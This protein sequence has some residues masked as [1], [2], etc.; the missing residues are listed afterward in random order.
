MFNF[1][2]D[3]GATLAVS[4]G[5]ITLGAIAIVTQA[6]IFLL[7]PIGIYYAIKFLREVTS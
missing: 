2:K 3:I 7:V 5:L 4:L 6:I 1:F